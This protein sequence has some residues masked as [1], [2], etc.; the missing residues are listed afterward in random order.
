[1]REK[2]I[3]SA[4]LIERD[5]LS[6]KAAEVLR[7]RIIKGELAPGQKLIEEE[8]S[9]LLGVS[10]ACVREAVMQLENEGLIVRTQGRSREVATFG[11]TDF[12]EIYTL[13]LYIEKLAVATCLKNGTLPDAL[14]RKKAEEINRLVEKKPVN[15]IKL[16]EADLA[17]HEALIA[18][19]GN[20]RALQVWQGLKNQ[21]KTL[22]YLYF[23]T[24]PKAPEPDDYAN[25]VRLIETFQK[26]DKAQIDALLEAHILSG[27]TTMSAM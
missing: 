6:A 7:D 17:F 11:K 5:L 15:S 18:A 4:P 3:K 12:T 23:T 14:L 16:V 24:T 21:I 25:H 13:R 1:M 20:K 19:A 2:T 22:L 8:M 10:R 27:L 9:K 26:G